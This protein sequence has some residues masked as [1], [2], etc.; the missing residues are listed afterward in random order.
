MSLT[1]DARDRK[2]PP[3]TVELVATN[4]DEGIVVYHPDEQR[5]GSEWIE[6]DEYIEDVRKRK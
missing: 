5:M 1:D 2:D 4:W 6:S 3:P